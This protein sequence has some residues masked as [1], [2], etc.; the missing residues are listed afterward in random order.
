MSRKINAATAAN[1]AIASPIARAVDSPA[2]ALAAYEAQ[3]SGALEWIL[4]AHAA[5]L[6]GANGIEGVT[7]AAIRRGLAKL[8]ADP[9]TSDA[10]VARIEKMGKLTSRARVWLHVVLVEPA[11]L[12]VVESASVKLREEMGLALI[13]E[14]AYEDAKAATVETA[15]DAVKARIA[16]ATGYAMANAVPVTAATKALATQLGVPDAG[17]LKEKPKKASALQMR[18]TLNA[19]AH[20]VANVART[21]QT[22]LNDDSLKAGK[23]VAVRFKSETEA[24]AFVKALEDAAAKS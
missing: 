4:V 3:K 16:G 18:M 11:A 14:G 13:G 10:L 12:P 9:E 21:P 15:R 22:W 2:F 23:I 19:L 17:K 24:A 6:G 20:N 7:A 1:A 8:K 5:K